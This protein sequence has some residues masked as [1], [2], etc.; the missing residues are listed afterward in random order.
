MVEQNPKDKLN[1]KEMNKKKLIIKSIP[2]QRTHIT[3]Y[4]SIFTRVVGQ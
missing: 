3:H 1:K 2:K 4:H